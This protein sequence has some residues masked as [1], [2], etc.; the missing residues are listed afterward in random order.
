V[1]STALTPDAERRGVV[2][3][4]CGMGSG[5]CT[6]TLTATA[7]EI[8]LGQVPFHLAEESTKDIVLPVPVP[9]GA[10]QVTLVVD[11]SV[12][13]GSTSPITVPVM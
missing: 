5:G 7:G 1:T 13:V 4:S 9:A 2:Q 8:S 3:L 10:S 12:G 6:G 11:R